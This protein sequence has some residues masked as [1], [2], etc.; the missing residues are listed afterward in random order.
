MGAL[1][2]LSMNLILL[3]ETTDE[4]NLSV[5]IFSLC[6]IFQQKDVTRVG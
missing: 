2:I 6:N 3:F 4:I 1:V 5:L